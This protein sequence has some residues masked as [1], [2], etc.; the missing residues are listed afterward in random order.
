MKIDIYSYDNLYHLH[1]TGDLFH[2]IFRYLPE[3]EICY[4]KIHEWF[5]EIV[6]PDLKTK[7]RF[8]V[9]ASIKGKFAGYMILKKLIK[10]KKYVHYR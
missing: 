5:D 3:I 4:P 7:N 1:D 6:I 2:N 9:K 8:I 10:R